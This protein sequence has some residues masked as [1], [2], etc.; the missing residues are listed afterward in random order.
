MVSTRFQEDITLVSQLKSALG[1]WD[2]PLA[3]DIFVDTDT[4]AILSIP[5]SVV[6][7]EDTICWH[8][9]NDGYYTF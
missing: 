5:M 3:R 4:T 1:N 6:Q 9:S 7:R 2:I 8:F